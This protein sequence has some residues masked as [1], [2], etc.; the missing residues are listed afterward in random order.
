MLD[1]LYGP[2]R[3]LISAAR[4]WELSYGGSGSAADY[5]EF[6]YYLTHALANPGDADA[7]D[8]DVVSMEEAYLY[9]L[10]HDT[11]QSEDLTSA[12]PP[13]CGDNLGEHPSYYSNPWD[14]GRRLSL[15]GLAEDIPYHP[16]LGTYSQTQ[17][18]T[19]TEIQ[20]IFPTGGTAKNWRAD[21][22]FWSFS[23]PFNFP[24]GSQTY[25]TVWVDSNGIIYLNN[26]G[27]SDWQNSVDGLIG[28]NAIAPLW[29]DLTTAVTG[30]D[31]F[32]TTDSDWATIRWQAH[33]RWD[34]RPVN[35]A[36]RLGKGGEIRFLY[37]GGNNHT[38]RIEQRDKTIGISLGSNAYHLCLRNGIGDLGNAKG[39]E[40]LPYS[41]IY[42]DRN[43]G[44]TEQG[45]K[46]YPYN[47]IKEGYN[48]I[49]KYGTL[50]IKGGAYTGSQNV[51][52]TFD[53]P[54]TTRSY[55]GPTVIGSP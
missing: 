38:S 5:D 41:V 22:S 14:L 24:Y 49:T 48:A 36:A 1:N 25:S 27:S 51:P 46:A 6:S 11:V 28:K 33:T 21:D 45:T 13:K 39:I 2:N 43:N 15:Y 8:N 34:G 37:G 29:D 17:G 10:A 44:G 3:L 18:Y 32:T 26:P 30:D 55:D 19:Q 52:I 4:F 53:K 31:I 20:E 16:L 40:Y 42:V 23:L 12:T 7:N 9:A 50:S 54:I 35:I 47:T